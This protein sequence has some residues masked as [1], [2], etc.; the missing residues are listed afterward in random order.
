MIINLKKSIYSI[1]KLLGSGLFT[2]IGFVILASGRIYTIEDDISLF[3]LIFVQF[4]MIGLTI[5]KFGIDNLIYANYIS[6]NNYKIDPVE[7]IKKFGIYL[8]LLFCIISYF[9][10]NLQSSI[11]LFFLLIFDTFSILSLIQIS[12][13]GNY[14]SS[15]IS[16]FLSYPLFFLLFFGISFLY[17][18]TKTQILFL[19]VL[20][21][22]L[23]AISSF[24]NFKFIIQPNSTLNFNYK[25]GFQQILNYVIFKTDQIIF[26]FGVISALAFNYNDLDLKKFIFLSKFPEIVSGVMVSLAV[27]YTPHLYI[28]SKEKY[29]YII[30]KYKIS[31]LLA[32]LLASLG[33]F[34]Y[35]FLWKGDDIISVY[36]LLPYLVHVLLIIVVNMI[37]VGFLMDQKI[38]NLIKNLIFSITIGLVTLL[39]VVLF[40]I[41]NGILWAIPIQLLTFSLLPFFQKKRLLDEH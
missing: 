34:F 3:V 4:Q 9:T 24:Y 14:N 16:N 1:F 18:L 27:L 32:T 29:L 35:S 31:I 6:D 20:C 33:M 10:F 28:N 39:I 22:I 12:A 19:L 15:L 38:N 36:L 40:K 41:T 23:R 26:S 17:S 13:R 25:I 2:T 21:S 7:Y 5:S 11:F 8:I 37:T 30:S